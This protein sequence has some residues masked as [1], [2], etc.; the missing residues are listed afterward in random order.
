MERMICMEI[1]CLAL[2]AVCLL[3]LWKIHLLRKAAKEIHREFEQKLS[4]DTNTP[5]VISTRDISM[6]RL[7]AGINCQ[8]KFLNRERRRFQHG[9]RELKEAVTNIS[10]D[11]RTPLTAISGYLDLLEQEKHTREARRYLEMIR[12]R[13]NALADLT[14]ELFSYSVITSGEENTEEHLSLNRVLEESLASYY[15]AFVQHNITPK[16]SIS[17]EK[18]ERFLNRSALMRIFGNIISN[19][20]KYSDGDLSVVMKPDGTIVFANK[21]AGL[22]PVLAGRLFDRFYTVETGSQSTGLGLAIAKQLCER[23]GGSIRADYQEE[24]LIITLFFP[25]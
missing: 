23:M 3:L 19:A 22:T 4:E 5:I 9:D 6:R 13:T 20:L 17:E 2:L 10:H 25:K 24:K 16:I 1:L 8:L 21:A 11:L 12:R 14:E 7:A 15:G 18:A